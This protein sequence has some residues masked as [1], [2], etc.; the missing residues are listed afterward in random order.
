MNAMPSGRAI[1][2]PAWIERDA[3]QQAVFGGHHGSNVLDAGQLSHAGVRPAPMSLKDRQHETAR[4]GRF[5]QS[6]A[7]HWRPWNGTL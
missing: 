5:E 7:C 2:M 3:A 4:I 6:A 1:P